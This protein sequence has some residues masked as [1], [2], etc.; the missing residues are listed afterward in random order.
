[1]DWEEVSRDENHVMQRISIDQL[2]GTERELKP[3]T[4]FLYAYA[5]RQ[6]SSDAGFTWVMTM[7]F[8]PG[9]VAAA[10]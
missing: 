3:S 7:A 4:G 6:G 1:M 5:M 8:V 9:T 2:G 10:P